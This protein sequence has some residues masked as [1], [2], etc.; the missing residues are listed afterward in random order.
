MVLTCAQGPGCKVEVE[1]A[2]L[3]GGRWR[4]VAAGWPGSQSWCQMLPIGAIN[5]AYS[6]GG[7]RK[8]HPVKLTCRSQCLQ[9]YCC[10]CCSR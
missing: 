6:N 1:S 8:A 10:C 9:V 7:I 4:A 3:A 5:A 2:A